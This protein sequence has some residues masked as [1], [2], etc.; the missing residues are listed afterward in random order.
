MTLTE[1]IKEFALDLGYGGVGIT[2][3]QDFTEYEDIVKS[4]GAQYDFF[5]ESATMRS[6]IR[7]KETMPS[8]KSILVLAYDYV[9]KAFPQTL[10]NKV[11]RVYL[12]RSYHPP[13]QRING[14][15]FELMKNFLVQKGCN[16]YTDIDLPERYAAARAGVATFGRNNFA[17]ADGIGSF[18]VISA[19]VI[20]KELE[21]DAPT[22]E[23]KCPA[24]CTACMDACPTKAIYEP[25]KLNPRRC[26]GFNAWSTREDRGFGITGYIPRDIREKMGTHVHGCDLCQEACPRNRA[27]LNAKFPQDAFLEMLA[28]D[29][30]LTQLL[31]MP[32]GFYEARVKPIMY[33]YIKKQ[34]YFQRNA[35]VAMGNTGDASYVPELALAMGNPAEI[36]R[37]HAA[38]ALGK[39]GGTEAKQALELSFKREN[40]EKVKE[41]INMALE[42][43][44]RQL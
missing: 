20:D 1:E 3:A 33:N 31:H 14:A 24:E 38:W 39:I 4:R 8:A 6:G 11:A 36:V 23:C 18:I 9:Q 43:L 40:S 7:P 30:S 29:F 41:E 22:M 12:S 21:Y 2:D 37:A 34:K 27:K 44:L 17:Y 32:D 42:I 19:M 10:L 5:R 35:A 15:R 13:V 26:L 25:F 28:K 16:V